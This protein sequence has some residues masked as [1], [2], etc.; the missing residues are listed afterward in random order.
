MHEQGSFAWMQ[1]MA[2]VAEL[3]RMFAPPS[4]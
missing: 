4:A 1:A 3:R 2:P